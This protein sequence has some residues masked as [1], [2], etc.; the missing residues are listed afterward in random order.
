MTPRILSQLGLCFLAGA[1]LVLLFS[2]W[3][4]I[5]STPSVGLASFGTVLLVLGIM[6]RVRARKAAL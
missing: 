4:S 3:R 5:T 2:I 1:I 6:M